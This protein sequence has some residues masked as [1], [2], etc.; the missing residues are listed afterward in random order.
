MLPA[1]AGVFVDAI[2]AGRPVIATAFPHAVELLSSG[3]GIVVPHG[4]PRAL[5]AAIRSVVTDSDVAAAMA[6]RA[7]RLAPSLAWSAVA[8]QYCR[9][10]DEIIASNRSVAI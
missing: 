2:A 8:E 1:A 5:A 7:G 4:D 6:A 3:A 10:S 9:L